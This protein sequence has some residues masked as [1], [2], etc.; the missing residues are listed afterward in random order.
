MKE[1]KLEEQLKGLIKI[2]R[3]G[4]VIIPY[5]IKNY[6]NCFKDQNCY[7]YREMEVKNETRR[8]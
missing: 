4:K 2:H 3:G 6:E 7:Y 5:C 8:S 1:N